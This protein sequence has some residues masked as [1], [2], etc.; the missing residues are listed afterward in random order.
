MDHPPR[1]ER[2]PT[3]ADLRRQIAALQ[4]QV[5]DLQIMCE[6]TVEHGTLIENELE[7]KNRSI[8][9]L[10]TLMKMY[11]PS[12]LYESIAGGSLGGKLTYKR[13]KLTMFFS[14]IV[15]FTDVTDTL[16]PETLSSVLN[17]YLTEMSSIATVYGGTV[18]KFIGDAIV[19]FFGD[20]Q[21]TD[22][23]THAKQCLRMATDMLD[24]IKLL[25]GK[26]RAAGATRDEPRHE[27]AH[28]CRGA[29]DAVRHISGEVED[30][31]D[32]YV[33]VREFETLAERVR[34]FVERLGRKG[35]I[36][37]DDVL[38][39]HVRMT[40]RPLKILPRVDIAG[41]GFRGVHA[42]QSERAD[43]RPDRGV[44]SRRGH[45]CRRLAE[46]GRAVQGGQPLRPTR[47]IRQVGP[48]FAR[49]CQR[50]Q[51]ERRLDSGQVAREHEGP[52]RVDP[53]E[54]RDDRG[55]GAAERRIFAH[56]LHPGVVEHPL[57]DDDDPVRARV[58]GGCHRA[59]EEGFTIDLEEGLRGAAQTRGATA[60]EDDRVEPGA[61]RRV[62]S[63]PGRF[64]DPER[65]PSLAVMRTFSIELDLSSPFTMSTIASAATETAVRA[66]ISTPVRSAVRTVASIATP[67]SSIARSTDAPC[68]PMM[69]ARG[70]SSAQR[71]APWIPAM[72][73]TASTSP[74]GTD[75][76]RSDATTSGAHRT[77][78]RAVAERTVGCLSVTSTMRAWPDSSRWVKLMR[79]A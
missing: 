45:G 62:H 61:P 50:K 59:G 4:E 49:I 24:K 3:I 23:E 9:K 7:E 12:Q 40:A 57:S 30:Q 58:A 35:A 36:R 25:S 22:D 26:W 32:V 56:P 5:S 15:G 21:F 53:R 18:D 64:H 67:S 73:A 48:V 39:G 2:P 41:R 66:S 52:L 11:L 34:P 68:T 1:A 74:F 6:N 72:R 71:F 78:P 55:D 29:G 51:G 13:K 42:R 65:P 8:N 75:P 38:S 76:S 54:R 19:I 69:C 37:H 28:G 43:E 20:P 44:A 14:D 16:E 17:E 70:S 46:S 47:G 10:L 63:S 60:R 27:S 79:P 31:S 77:N 33:V